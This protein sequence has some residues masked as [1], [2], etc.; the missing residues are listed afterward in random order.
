VDDAFSEHLSP[1]TSAMNQTAHDA[2]LREL[3]WDPAES[4]QGLL[5]AM[6]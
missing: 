2:M 5:R 6:L 3:S 4:R 1:Q